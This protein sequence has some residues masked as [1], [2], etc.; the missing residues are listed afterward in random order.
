MLENGLPG[1]FWVIGEIMELHE[2]R[3]CYLELVE[4]S[5]EKNALLA[6]ARATIWASRFG[7]LRP[8]FEASTGTTLKSGIK[9]LCKAS[10]EFHP[11]YGF[12]L[13]ITRY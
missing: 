6:K 12:S 3:H 4:K 7:M 2:N 10:V 5:E 8:F 1:H 9:I 13:N 11:Q